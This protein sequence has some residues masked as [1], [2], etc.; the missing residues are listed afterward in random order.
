MESNIIN[1][2]IISQRL[3]LLEGDIYLSNKIYSQWNF[4]GENASSIREVDDFIS[5]FE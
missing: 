3:L 4:T 5:N 2:D 1:T